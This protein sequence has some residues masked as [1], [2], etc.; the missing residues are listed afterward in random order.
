MKL[1]VKRNW[2]GCDGADL[3]NR[4]IIS[5]GIHEVERI[6]NPYGYSGYWIVLKG[7]LIGASEGFWRQW[8]GKEWDDFEVILKD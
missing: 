8:E 7:T 2:N 1:I 5:I 4:P 3:N 6:P